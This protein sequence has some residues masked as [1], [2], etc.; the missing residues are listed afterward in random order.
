MKCEKCNRRIKHD[1]FPTFCWSCVGKKSM[2]RYLWELQLL[3]W[4]KEA[5][6]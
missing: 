1:W 2:D 4:D 5:E 6:E 3:E